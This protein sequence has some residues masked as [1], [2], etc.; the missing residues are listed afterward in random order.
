MPKLSNLN[1]N[2]VNLMLITQ[3]LT[4]AILWDTLPVKPNLALFPDARTVEDALLDSYPLYYIRKPIPNKQVASFEPKRYA[5]PLHA[6][7]IDYLQNEK[8]VTTTLEITKLLGIDRNAAA[9]CLYELTVLGKLRK[10]HYRHANSDNLYTLAERQLTLEDIPYGKR[11]DHILRLRVQG[12]GYTVIGRYY[13]VLPDVIRR[14]CQSWPLK[15]HELLAP[16]TT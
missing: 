13:N 10:L 8:R 12:Y 9:D 6:D 11:N 14:T 4:L 1:S 16:P 3:P 15:R 7:I 5:N 2:A